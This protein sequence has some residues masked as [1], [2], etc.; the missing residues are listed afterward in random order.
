M[1]TSSLFCLHKHTPPTI[2]TLSTKTHSSDYACPAFA[3]TN[4]VPSFLSLSSP[5]PSI[6]F[7]PLSAAHFSTKGMAAAASIIHSP[8]EQVVLALR[9]AAGGKREAVEERLKTRRNEEWSQNGWRLWMQRRRKV[10]QRIPP[11]GNHKVGKQQQ[12]QKKAKLHV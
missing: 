2:E 12:P 10:Q 4:H 5:D 6:S 11:A 8:S 7:I 9:G 3:L 1:I